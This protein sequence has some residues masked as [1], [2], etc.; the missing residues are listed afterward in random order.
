MSDGDDTQNS[1]YQCTAASTTER[2]R[3]F[4]RSALN[5]SAVASPPSPRTARPRALYLALVGATVAAGLAS[6]RYAN[7]LPTAV[8][9]YAGDVLW[10]AMA[11]L[12]FATLWAS[13]PVGRLALTA[14]GFAFAI[15]T[16][17]LYHAPWID[18]IRTT[19]PGALVLG[20][21][22][23]WSDLACYTIGVALAA[24]LDAAILRRLDARSLRLAR[25]GDIVS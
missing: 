13:A 14:L 11:Y 21:G 5:P 17:Q 10:A 1:W 9:L 25:H 20:F 6:R 7:V 23:L 22:F 15:E 8:G 12:L 16:S 18:A 24:G 2:G 19:R 3:G 4:A